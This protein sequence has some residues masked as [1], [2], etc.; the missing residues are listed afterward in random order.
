MKESDLKKKN[1]LQK[2]VIPRREIS[3]T[4]FLKLSE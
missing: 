4:A 3:L 1:L 2:Y